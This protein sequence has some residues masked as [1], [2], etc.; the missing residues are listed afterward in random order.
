MELQ[1]W[2]T[3]WKKQGAKQLRL[4]LMNHWDPI[5][6]RGVPEAA[7]EYDGYLGQIANRLQDEAGP[8]EIAD[9]LTWV[10]SDRMGLGDSEPDRRDRE[11]A[12]VI[13]DWYRKMPGGDALR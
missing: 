9:Y 7:D 10:R 3:W 11:T 5:G 13:C 12:A 6:V 1:D 2:Q 4:I 8:A